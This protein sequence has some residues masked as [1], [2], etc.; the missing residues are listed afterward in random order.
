MTR[1]KVVPGYA[2][3]PE[4]KEPPMETSDRARQ[5]HVVSARRGD[6]LRRAAKPVQGAQ[7]LMIDE[8]N[9]CSTVMLVSP[10]A[11]HDTESVA[12]FSYPPSSCTGRLRAVMRAILWAQ[13][14]DLAEPRPSTSEAEAAYARVTTRQQLRSSEIERQNGELHDHLRQNQASDS[15]GRRVVVERTPPREGNAA[16]DRQRQRHPGAAS[17]GHQTHG[18]LR[19]LPHRTGGATPTA[20]YAAGADPSRVRGSRGGTAAPAWTPRSAAPE[21]AHADRAAEAQAQLA[22]C[23]DGCGDRCASPGLWRAEHPALAGSRGWARMASLRRSPTARSRKPMSASP[24]PPA[25]GPQCTLMRTSATLRAARRIDC[26]ANLTE[27]SW[28]AT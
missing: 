7:W 21:A 16:L 11:G 3:G 8:P 4:E 14:S 23:R 18:A 27:R 1:T 13:S 5:L 28:R 22:P 24:T 17:T 9:Q 19:R 26:R 20:A 2:C 25:F 10:H 15:D 12:G 6:E